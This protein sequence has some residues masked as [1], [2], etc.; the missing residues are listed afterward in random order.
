MAIK[1]SSLL[2]VFKPAIVCASVEI[3]PGFVPS[4]AVKVNDVPLIVPPAAYEVVF[5]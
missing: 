4:A 5:V 1:P 2:N 3:K